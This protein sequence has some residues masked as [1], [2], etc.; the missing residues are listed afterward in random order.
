MAGHSKWAQIKRKKAANDT[1]RGKMFNKLIREITVA[2][3]EGGG[4]PDAN[5]RLRLAVDTAKAANMPNDNID[6]AILRG[7]GDLEGVEYHEVVYEGYG[8]GGVALYIETL[9]DNTNR[10]VA[11]VRH[12]LEKHGG[13]LG[14]SGSV[15]WQF[16]KKGQILIEKGG[17]DE[18]DVMLAALEAGAEDVEAGDE[19]YIVTTAFTD[20]HAARDALTAEG[21]SCEST[22]LTMVPKATVAVSGADAEALLRLVDALED[23]DD[24]QDVH[25]NADVDEATAAAAS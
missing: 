2:A 17:A 25:S 6:R 1:K 15:A 7:T 23:L 22:E 20:L 4:D 21:L 19:V 5:P 24:V 3:R 9:T 12:A 16:A 13:N 8:P 10:T 11:E 14:Q 18:D